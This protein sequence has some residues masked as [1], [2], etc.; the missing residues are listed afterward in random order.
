MK[1]IK[2]GTSSKEHRRKEHRRKAGRK[3]GRQADR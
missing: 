2:T 3:A 1:D